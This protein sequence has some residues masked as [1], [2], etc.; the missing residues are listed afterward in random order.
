MRRVDDD[1]DVIEVVQEGEARELAGEELDAELARQLGEASL[2]EPSPRRTAAK[3]AKKPGRKGRNDPPLDASMTTK[4]PALQPPTPGTPGAAAAA[5]APPPPAAAA[6]PPT[7]APPTVAPTDSVLWDVVE[8]RREVERSL[9]R[10]EAAA[11]PSTATAEEI[12]WRR[13]MLEALVSLQRRKEERERVVLTH[14]ASHH[15]LAPQQHD[16][17]AGMFAQLYRH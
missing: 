17:G 1:E 4:S 10:L 16:V 5:A 8:A 15:R 3:K 12:A 14:V 11:S 9:A 2:E 6:A 7:V 13:R